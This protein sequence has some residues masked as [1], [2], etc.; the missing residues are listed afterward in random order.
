MVYKAFTEAKI[1]ITGAGSG[2]GKELVRQLQESKPQIL[3]VDFN[4]DKLWE[5]REEFPAIKTLLVDLREKSGNKKILDWVKENWERVDFCFANAGKAEFG[6]NKEQN[7]GE[8]DKLFQLNVHSPIQ[9]GYILKA[10]FPQ[11]PYRHIITASAMAYWPIPGYSLY[12]ATKSALLQWA[13][14]VWAEKTGNWLSLVFPIATK[15]AFFETAGRDVPQAWPRQ[16]AEWVASET[17]RGVAK[18][19]KRI[20]PSKLFFFMLI[21]T[22]FLRILKRIVAM[23]EY[24]RYK[25]WLEKQSKS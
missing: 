25:N 9:L 19:K 23:I 17:L 18:G 16:S 3:V 15:T 24:R 21:I 20:Y 6:P 8:M 12:G 7:W 1:I 11:H 22:R 10:A 14:T 4:S 5:L 13:R 2:I